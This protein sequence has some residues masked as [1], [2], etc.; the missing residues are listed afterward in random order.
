MTMGSAR[1]GRDAARR[2]G[3]FHGRLLALPLS[4]EASREDPRDDGA[5]IHW[6]RECVVDIREF[7]DGGR[8]LSFA[9]YL[10][11]GGR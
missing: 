10:E 6:A 8:Y 1:E 11:G 5:N 3:A 4:H 7:S 2:R 9:G